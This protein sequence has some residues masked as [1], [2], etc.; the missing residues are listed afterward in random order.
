MLG[1]LVP[2]LAYWLIVRTRNSLFVFLTLF[3]SIPLL[4][5]FFGPLWDMVLFNGTPYNQAG[6][7]PFYVSS[8]L[9]PLVSLGLACF[10]KRN[11][12]IWVAKPINFDH[13]ES[14]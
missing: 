2:G 5:L 8:A 1:L 10:A 13:N 14:S 6:E 11:R 7:L 12:D 9:V 3:L 4:F